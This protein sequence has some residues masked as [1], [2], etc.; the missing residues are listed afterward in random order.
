MGQSV[1]NCDKC[2]SEEIALIH[3]TINHIGA[4]ISYCICANCKYPSRHEFDNVP[5]ERVKVTLWL[6][7]QKRVVREVHG[8]AN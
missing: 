1:F 2:S 5:L 6:D 4:M 3:E 8:Y 7:P